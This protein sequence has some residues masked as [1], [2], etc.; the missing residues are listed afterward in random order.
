M[1]TSSSS[2][3]QSQPQ[4]EGKLKVEN[5]KKKDSRTGLFVKNGFDHFQE[6]HK[7]LFDANLTP[8]AKLIPLTNGFGSVTI[9]ID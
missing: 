1:S 9:I 3:S 5:E 8:D 6:W 4:L 7:S 2:S